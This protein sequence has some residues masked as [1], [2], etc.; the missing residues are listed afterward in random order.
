[1]SLHEQP[2]STLQEEPRS[3][4]FSDHWCTGHYAID[5]RGGLDAPDGSQYCTCSWTVVHK[6]HGQQ[7]AVMMC[8]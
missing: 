1:M 5:D 6:V 4:P 8:W 2:R 7:T 3:F